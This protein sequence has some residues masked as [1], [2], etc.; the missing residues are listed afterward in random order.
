[1]LIRPARGRVKIFI[2]AVEE[3]IRVRTGERGTEAI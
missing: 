1:M 2:S 3:A